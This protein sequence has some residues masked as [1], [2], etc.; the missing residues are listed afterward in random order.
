M[1]DEVMTATT[2]VA[3]PIETVFG[4][5]AD[6]ALHQDIDGTGWVRE[7]VDPARLTASGEIFRVAMYHENH[8]DGHYEMANRVEAFSPPQVISWRPGQVDRQSGELGF[9][10]W[11]WRY[12]LTTTGDDTTEVT[13]TYDWSAVPASLREHI[14]FPPFPAA[15]LENS[16]AHLAQLAATR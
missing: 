15:H 13:L 4:V 2:T 6:P 8:P 16:L 10:G 9:G 14:A 12:D 3:A 1:S 11:S 5:L 7:A